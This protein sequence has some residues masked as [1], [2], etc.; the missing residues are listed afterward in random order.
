AR[1]SASW[2]GDRLSRSITPAPPW[3]AK[4]QRGASW[5]AA[6]E[7]RRAVR[8]AKA[9]VRFMRAAPPWAGSAMMHPLP[10]AVGHDGRETADQG[11]GQHRPET[12]AQAV[13]ADRRPDPGRQQRAEPGQP[14][15]RGPSRT[16]RDRIRHRP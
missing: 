9:R 13:L 8:A 2:L 12:A 6:G 7:A 10:D 5:A 14:H 1:Y 3:M 15:R 4:D 11:R 16:P